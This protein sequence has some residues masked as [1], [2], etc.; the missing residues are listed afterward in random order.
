MEGQKGYRETGKKP[1]RYAVVGGYLGA[2]KTT[3]LI[4]F[5]QY[6]RM[7]GRRPAILVNDLGAKNLVDGTV[8]AR[9]EVCPAMEITGDCI[10]YQT[11]NLV[12]KLRRFRDADSAEM[13]FSDIPGCGIGGLDHVY[14]KLDQEYRGEFR[15]SPFT[16]IADPERLRM[17]MPEKADIHLPEE[18]RYLFEAQLKEAEVII[19]NKIDLLTPE[20]RKRF[21][22]FLETTYPHAKVFLMSAK[23]GE[24]VGVCAEYLMEQDSCLPVKD[25]GY[26]GPE[27]MAAELTMS[28]YNSQLYFKAAQPLD[29]NALIEDIMERV[30]VRLRE[31]GRN[32]PHLKILAMPAAE[33]A[34]PE[35]AKASLTG[36][37]HLVEF[38]RRLPEI[39]DGIVLVINARAVCESEKLSEILQDAAEEAAEQAGAKM[40]VYF[41]ECFGMMDEGRL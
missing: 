35:H 10:C 25:I 6:L 15:L 22:A 34:V 3:S 36:I 16:A 41:T 21:R 27:F 19:L 20:E 31:A 40:R 2:G 39:Y 14:H 13:I 4:A 29:G 8:T 23:T 7:T 38:E 26:G 28:W 33:T 17:I 11:E 32:V 12:D 18:M 5:S 30:R 24:N 37:D 9:A 1:V